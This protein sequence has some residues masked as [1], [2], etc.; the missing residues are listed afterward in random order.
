[1]NRTDQGVDLS[2]IISTR[3][4]DRY[5]TSSDAS[6]FA[7]IPSAV[8]SAHS[9]NQIAE[10]FKYAS[11]NKT[12]VT[13][14]S[15]GTSLS[16]QGVTDGILID[17]RKHFRSIEVLDGGRQVKV[18]PGATVRAVN[19]RL[20]R[21]ARKLGPDPASEIACTIGGVIANNSSGMACGITDNTYRTLASATVVLANGAIIGTADL[22]AEEKLK[23]AAPAIYQEL[24]AIRQV[25]RSD[26]QLAKQISD[27]YQIK[28]TMGYGLNSFVDFDS[29]I[30]IFM[31]IIIGSEGTLGFVSEAIFNTV[32][33]LKYA[34]TTLI[35]FEDLI[36]AT[37]ALDVLIPTKP[38]TI[39]LMD[40]P[41]LRAGKVDLAGLTLAN[42]AALLVEY[43]AS[44]E[45]S[46]AVLIES[47][48]G[49]ITA[50][51]CVNK[52]QLIADPIERAKLWHIRKGL[53][54]AVAGARKSGT[55]ALLED[56]A[57]PPAHLAATCIGLQELFLK[58]GYDD[59]VIFGHAKDGNIHFLV[60]EDFKDPVK[61]A[62][63]QSFT[64]DMVE[65]V[66]SH[67]GSLKAE[68]GTGRMMAPFVERQFG[69]QL[70]ELMLRIKKAFDPR[71]ILNP[72]VLIT[73]DSS[74]HLK[75]IK[76]NPTISPVADR[77]VECGYCEPICPSKDLTTTP[78]Q[79]I[80]LSRAIQSA[81][82]RGDSKLARSLDQESRYEVEDTC[83]V[84]GLCETSCPVG[85]NTGSLVRELRAK[86][87]G[88]FN[89]LMWNQSAKHWNIALK[90][91]VTL[92][93]IAH[94]TPTAVVTPINHGLR[95][96]FGSDVV[97]LWT[98]DLPQ[99]GSPR[100][101]AFSA[102][103]PDFV[104]FSSCLQTIF[105]S[106][107]SLS[108][109]SLVNKA[110]LS[111][112]T[113][114]GISD[115]CCATPW[116]SKGIA[117]GYRTMVEKTVAALM[118]SSRN[119]ALP[120][121][122]DNSSCTEGLVDAVKA[123]AG[124]KLQIIDSVDF[125]AQ[126]LLP[127]LHVARQLEKVAIHPTCSSTLSGSNSN[128]ELLA[129]SIS[130]SVITPLDWGC[131]AFAGDRGLL[132]PELTAAATAPEVAS[133]GTEEFDAYLSTN[134][135]CEIALSRASGAR[136]E[137]VLVKLDQFS[138]SMSSA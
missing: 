121:V 73:D 83:A 138:T 41:S 93:K 71:G 103:N 49:A 14:R 9:A 4:I 133:I 120:I 100:V 62:R 32:P 99:T 56:I 31:H 127:R 63:Y 90:K 64:E 131:C 22:N 13:F 15:G 8:A 17:T 106:E 116:K 72:G 48:Q 134:L 136:Y 118:A 132:H 33:L 43:Q 6:H 18:Q 70:Y 128:L 16:G 60:N 46:L 2:E 84:D 27:Q 87:V 25:V 107:T 58:H 113:P 112:I 110:G 24:D 122:C 135:T 126:T 88:S 44:D 38:A 81:I 125:A 53:Y 80:V 102:T 61:S 59:A 117:S 76:F 91:I 114:E 111:F 79:R 36:T 39:E 95:K 92:Q 23:S 51:P 130:Q 109:A 94:A 68:H 29:V 19:A 119:G 82:E 52:P 5:R 85:I 77:C 66:L 50:L 104:F 28:N 67:S 30:D 57:V 124:G 75:N 26:P 34:A 78:R 40:A 10:L 1:M 11:S 47:A 65:L 89:S 69:S 45:Q 108:F 3:D 97:P 96:L 12:S 101:H 123:V 42:H 7:L 21:F 35:I 54:A 20:A 74:S 137:H 98:H 37:Q 86:R 115:L 55:T 129:S 105:E